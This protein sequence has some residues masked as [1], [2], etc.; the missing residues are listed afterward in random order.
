[1]SMEDCDHSGKASPRLGFLGGAALAEQQH[2]LLDT[3]DWKAPG[4]A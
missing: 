1:M 2:R 3:A 4:D